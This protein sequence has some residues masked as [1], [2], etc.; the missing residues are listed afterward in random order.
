MRTI[1]LIIILLLTLLRIDLY[2]QEI[3]RFDH[4]GTQDG[5]SQN[6]VS[7]MMCD[8]EG[9]LWIGTNNGLNRY[10]G[11]SFKV[12]KGNTNESG[13]FINNRITEI[14]QDEQDFIWFMTHDGYYHYFHPTLEK[15]NSIPDFLVKEAKD[16]TII[17]DFEQYTSNEIWIG[18]RSLGIYRLQYDAEQADY[19]TTRFLNRGQYALSNNNVSFVRHDN[20]GNL[21]IGTQRGIN[22]LSKE[23][24]EANTPNFQHFFVDY[25]FTTFCET[26]DEL[27]FG[28]QNNGLL[29]KNKISGVYTQKNNETVPLFK[30]N[31]SSLLFLSKREHLYAAF[32]NAGLFC[33]DISKKDWKYIPTAGKNIDRIYEDRYGQI[34]IT[35]DKFGIDR[36]DPETGESKHYRLSPPGRE[37]TTDLERHVFF[38]DNS[39][40]FWIGLHEGGLALYRRDEDRF[41]FYLNE[42]SNP[43]SIHSNIVAS[44][45]HD[46]S[47]QLW[48]GLGQYPG[49]IE[50]VILRNPGFTHILPQRE[51]KEVSDNI[52][53]SLHEDNEGRIWVGTKAGRLHVLDSLYNQ[54][55]VYEKFKTDNGWVSGANIY[56]IITDH[57]GHIWLGTKGKGILVSKKP[58]NE[59]E[60]LSHL[61]FYNYQHSEN[62][63]RSVTHNNI[64][65]IV[66]NH[67][68]EIWIGT[69]GNGISRVVTEKNGNRYFKNIHSQNSNLGSNMVRHI[70]F[71][72]Q[73]RMWV[74][75]SFGL[76][77]RENP[78]EGDFY[79]FFY[80]PDNPNSL[81]YN[82]VIHILEDSDQELW[83]GTLGG[84]LN[85]LQ[86]INDSVA[87]FKRFNS[88]N[89]LSNDVVLSMLEDN[90]GR[91]WISTENGLNRYNKTTGTI[92]VFNTT[93]GLSFNMFMENT[94]LKRQNGT[95]LFGGYKG[96]EALNCK[97]LQV[98][99][100]TPKIELT[101]FQLFNKDVSTLDENS[102]LEKTITYTKHLTLKHHQSS[103]SIEFSALDFQD[104]ENVQYAYMLENFDTG[105]NQVD[106]QNKATFTNLP[107]GDYVFKVKSTNRLGG[108]I[109]NP[110]ELKITIL[111][112]WYKTDWAYAGY[113]VIFILFIAGIKKIITKIN[114]YRNELTV[115][116]RINEEKLKFFTNIS[117]EIRTPLT[118][119]LG[120]LEDLKQK[121]RAISPEIYREVMI[122]HKNG[123]RMLHLI[124]QLLDFR[125]IQN[126]KMRLK[127]APLDI[128]KFC[129]EVFDSFLPMAQHKKLELAFVADK[130]SSE[131]WADATQ[132]DVVLYNIMSNAIKFTPS[133]KKVTI[134][135]EHISKDKLVISVADEG[136]GIPERNVKDLFTRYTILSNRE[137]SGTGIGLSL[138]YEITRLHGGEL[139]VDSKEGIGSTFKII[140]PKGRKHL[141]G[142]N[143]IEF[144]EKTDNHFHP[145][146]EDVI[147]PE[148]EKIT[149]PENG[150]QE[151]KAT[152]LVI[153][154]N[155]EILNYICSAL[156]RNFS[157]TKAANAREALDIIEEKH[158]DI[159]I[160]DV[161]M[162]GMDGMELTQ[163]LKKDF[164]TSHIPVVMLTAKTGLEDQ[165]SGLQC[166]AD[167]Y[168]QKPFNAKL[169]NTVALNLIEQRKRIIAKFRD[170]K[171]IDPETLK[172]TSKDEE[173][174]KT[175]V[176]YIQE[177]YSKEFTIEELAGQLC[178]SRTVFYNKVKG[179][180]GM[181]PVEFVRQLKLKIAAQL[182]EKGYNVS[183]VSF[184]VGFNDVKYFS[185]QFKT[186]FGYPPSKH[187]VEM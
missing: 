25:S 87:K 85:K 152:A 125:K 174:L 75:T 8:K 66:E 144:T 77:M 185:R 34:W 155:T 146:T 148:R 1:H 49:G 41:R 107:P 42:P 82:D 131:I 71:D 83:F 30:N 182:L 7:A 28:T 76:Y 6:T 96:I 67:E 69:Y 162:P 187:K 143:E 177:N 109:D 183:E 153:E 55:A 24:I 3:F 14:W 106:N 186:L 79:S 156:S 130:E 54:L 80:K 32:E 13:I 56:T 179:L 118:L 121:T 145:I 159:I 27:W 15:I 147:E 33:Y 175:L 26:K 63:P 20:T 11:Y 180:T 2:G 21:W 142:R 94:C 165:I 158:P 47:G 123:K 113:I 115:E 141:E 111:P 57:K 171:T 132:L 70:L 72:A 45:I 17:S 161:M 64:Y 51:I 38:E 119:I 108:W 97:K 10:D 78:R 167:A 112:P 73:G 124:N 53:R 36:Y 178:V 39:D 84:G 160:T 127:V 128:I 31:H 29:I 59:Y 129:R 163:L 139:K 12:F 88:S 43:N 181:S 140:L 154:D 184:Q 101:N 99:N 40:N 150:I 46:R 18:L 120:P 93:N 168:L 48:L 35:S 90:N 102:P 133:G 22:F 170:N 62:D 173:F 23:D 105:W 172:V 5:L 61:D 37:N 9:F 164:S 135:V 68:H 138:A 92:E 149:V 95:M 103:F 136:K 137:A 81:S 50:R 98:K 89:G 117:H 74:A 65:C 114:R 100:Y 122:I 60:S 91:L 86:V 166:G 110:S 134:S 16:N 151:K 52:T 157:T 116:K 58:V 44:I 4:I 126:N 19:K 169:L 176:A 104:P